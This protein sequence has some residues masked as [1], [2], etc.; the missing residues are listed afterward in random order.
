[1]ALLTETS[2]EFPCFQNE[3]WI[4][5]QKEALNANV[6]AIRNLASIFRKFLK[7]VWPLIPNQFHGTSFMLNLANISKLGRQ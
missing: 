1:M 6:I 5:F 4:C 7:N 2:A 3:G